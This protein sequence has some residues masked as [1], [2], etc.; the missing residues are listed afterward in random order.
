MKNSEKHSEPLEFAR[1]QEFIHLYVGNERCIYA[2][3][4]TLLHDWAAT[5]DTLQEAAKVMWTKFHEF[6]PGTDFLAWALCIAHYQVLKYRK[7]RP[8]QK[9]VFNSQLIEDLAR[10]AETYAHEDSPEQ[11]ALRRCLTK[12]T[13]RDRQLLELRYEI[14]ASVRTVAKHVGRGVNAVYKALNRIHNQLYH[15]I[16]STLAL[17]E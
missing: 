7:S 12:L 11:E 9:M 6:E 5:E 4:Y 10:Y 2:Y 3:I 8:T 1:G 13:E 17:E 14:N 16:L 15:C